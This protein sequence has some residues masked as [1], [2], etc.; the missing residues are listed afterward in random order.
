MAVRINQ[1][2]FPW[3]EITCDPSTATLYIPTIQAH[4]S[5]G[6]LILLQLE[7]SEE[8]I[9]IG[10]VLSVMSNKDKIAVNLW[11]HREDIAV[12]M[13]HDE[14]SNQLIELL[15]TN[16]V[17][18]VCWFQCLDV[19]FVFALE[20]VE[21][22]MLQL[23]AGMRER[24]VMSHHFDVGAGVISCQPHQVIPFSPSQFSQLITDSYGS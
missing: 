20:H 6:D 24:F 17:V 5:S 9:I 12:P 22:G 1:C 16:E 15:Q 7:D 11:H 13:V 4:L 14:P 19:A 3:A 21:D 2:H 10:L 8:A 23:I 18:S